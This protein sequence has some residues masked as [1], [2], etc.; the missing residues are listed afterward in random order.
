MVARDIDAA[1]LAAIS[2][3]A[4]FYPIVMVYLDWPGGAIRAHSN[5]GDLMWNSQT[6]S[7]VGNFGGIRLPG[8]EFGMAA[9]EATVSLHGLGDDLDDYLDTDP[10]GQDAVIYFGAVTERDG[11]TLVGDPFEVFT[12]T[13]DGL[14]DPTE[15]ANDGGYTRGVVVTLSSGPSQRSVGTAYHTFEDQSARY[16]GDTAGRLVVNAGAEARRFRWP[17]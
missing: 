9:Q 15:P 8:D 5:T 2:D 3:P 4:G 14:S 1:T 10:R 7:G 17:E 16:L 11:N 13:I 6:W 12:G